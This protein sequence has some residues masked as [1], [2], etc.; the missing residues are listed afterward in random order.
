MTVERQTMKGMNAQTTSASFQFVT[1]IK[2]QRAHEQDDDVAAAD[3]AHHD[4]HAHG[5]HIL[6][7]ARHEL[8]SLLLVVVGIGEPLE[9]VIDAVAKVVRYALADPLAQI[10][11]SVGE[12]TT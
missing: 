4:E 1:I 6:G 11:L 9:P 2:H 3:D 12:N 10:R 5:L 7:G 8:A